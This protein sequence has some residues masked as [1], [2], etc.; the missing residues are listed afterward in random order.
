MLLI[1]A[2]LRALLGTRLAIL[3]RYGDQWKITRNIHVLVTHLILVA[4]EI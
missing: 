4:R 3:M 2:F 1:S